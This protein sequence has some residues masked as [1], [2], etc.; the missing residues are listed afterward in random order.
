MLRLGFSLPPCRSARAP[1]L[2]LAL[3]LVLGTA[4]LYRGAPPPF[5]FRDGVGD[6]T[7]LWRC[8]IQNVV[9]ERCL[10]ASA[11]EAR[12]DAERDMARDL[13]FLVT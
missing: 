5:D 6:L 1:R 8:R 13:G 12:A 7:V 2:S 4:P 9:R 10:Q 11:A 3:P